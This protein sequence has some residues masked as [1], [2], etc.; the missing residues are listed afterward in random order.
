MARGE[1]QPAFRSSSR[2][3]TRR[4]RS[5]P[6]PAAPRIFRAWTLLTALLLG[7]LLH[8]RATSAA[9]PAEAREALSKGDYD[10]AL[11][12][13]REGVE[14]RPRDEEWQRLLAEGLWT[15][16][17]YPEAASVLTNTLARGPRSLATAWLAQQTLRSNGQLEAADAALNQI[18]QLI[19]E[20]TWMYRDPAD[21]IAVGRAMLVLGGDPKEI[22][23]RVF[24]TAKKTAPD[25]REIYLASG[26]LALAKHDSALAARHFDEGLKK[27]PKDADLLSGRARAF[28]DGDREEM[29]KSLEAALQANPRHLPSLLILADH[30]ID[31]EDYD[32]AQKSLDEVFAVNPSHPEAWAYASVLAHL[33]HDAEKEAKARAAALRYWTNNP[34]VPH[35][36]GLKLS[37][38]Y[39][40]AEGAARQREALAWDPKFL[41]A[42]AQLASDLLRLGEETEGWE[43]AQ[44]VH[45]ADGYD[46]A[47]FNLVTLHDTMVG[48]QTL[49]NE[50]FVLRMSQRE[51]AIYGDRALALLERARTRLATKYQVT[52][53]SPTIVEI[54]PQ[55]K[56]FGVRTF[57]MP[58]NPGY[59]GV[60]FGRVVT[61]NS[62][63]ANP[64]HPV[65][66]EA[67]LWH[68]FCHVVTLQL[69]ANKMPRWLSE[70]ISVYEERQANPA[71][72]EQPN[73]KYREMILDGTSLT[74]IGKLSAAFLTP[75]TPLHLQFAYYQSS[76]VVEFLVQKFGPECV[77][78]ILRD[79]RDKVFINEAIE[80]HTAPLATL[81]KDFAAYAK[82]RAEALGPGLDWQRPKSS[83]RAA[84]D[85]TE[86]IFGKL[87]PTN[88]W[89]LKEKAEALLE[90]KKWDEAKTPLETILRHYPGDVGGD[91][92]YPLLAQA[93]RELGERAEER[94]VLERWARHDADAPSAYLRLMELAQN[95]N[96]WTNVVH[97]AELFLAVNPLV[98][99]PYRHLALAREKLG[100]PRAAIALWENVLRLDPP[101]PVA[102]HYDV[103][104]LAAPLDAS[105]ARRHVLQALQDAPR[106]RAAL[107][108]LHQLGPRAS[109]TNTP[110][111]AASPPAAPTPSS[112]PASAPIASPPPAKPE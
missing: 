5:S 112:P 20:R 40:F 92:A 29:G 100:E 31:A 91:S 11:K 101:N 39:R 72:G 77:T 86:A 14:K 64:G 54:F 17:R 70:G 69:T 51:A 15:V 71:W 94:A 88:Y 46:V 58:D 24:G 28:A 67:V 95:Q 55:Q 85:P 30:R 48:F 56:D 23:D 110:V 34:T 75:K 80:R 36:I 106:H 4:P 3:P 96:E 42:K 102:V 22:L 66:W 25:L 109:A 82:E 53:A 89:A 87:S 10:R 45:E 79:L 19:S 78:K 2:P 81:E 62:P 57:G 35:L 111:N 65:N 13:A 60:C 68:E 99:A 33:R 52:L 50:H 21:L 107:R 97:H 12:L 73:P 1:S 63:A 16:G 26:E 7:G 43:L 61:A 27:F 105:Q 37:Q 6:T 41:P 108:L 47:A 74:P 98:P 90:Q 104:R 9:E 59:L 84:S 83:R 93:H 8:P 38:K 49:T 18:P 103:A 32:G 76:L 44:Q